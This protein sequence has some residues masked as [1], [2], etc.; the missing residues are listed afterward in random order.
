MVML[1]SWHSALASLE[2]QLSRSGIEPL[3]VT[4]M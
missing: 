4:V 1:W 2:T 3:F